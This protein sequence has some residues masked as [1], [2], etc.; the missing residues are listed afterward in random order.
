MKRKLCAIALMTR[1]LEYRLICFFLILSFCVFATGCN[2]KPKIAFKEPNQFAPEIVIPVVEL[3]DGKLLFKDNRQ[4]QKEVNWEDMTLPYDLVSIGAFHTLDP[5]LING[6]TQDLLSEFDLDP[7]SWIYP[8]G[9][10]WG[11]YSLGSQGVYKRSDTG[12]LVIP[13]SQLKIVFYDREDRIN[14]SIYVYVKAGEFVFSPMTETDVGGI[15]RHQGKLLRTRDMLVGNMDSKIGTVSA[16]ISNYAIPGS[17]GAFWWYATFSI[18][19]VGY[20]IQT[21]LDQQVFSE[22]LLSIVNTQYGKKLVD[23]QALI[24]YFCS[25]YPEYLDNAA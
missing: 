11:A 22:L 14:T 6:F 7:A 16:G 5:A 23:V 19:G 8:N 20:W 18:N 15:Y 13:D 3:T 24:D 1:Q 4:V 17:G 12:E 21:Q 10:Y 2:S 25:V 9:Y